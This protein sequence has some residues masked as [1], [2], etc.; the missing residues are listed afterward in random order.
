MPFGLLLNTSEQ[1]EGFTEEDTGGSSN[2]PYLGAHRVRTQSFGP[3]TENTKINNLLPRGQEVQEGR[4]VQEV[5][6]GHQDHLYQGDQLGPADRGGVSWVRTVL[7]TTTCQCF[8]FESTFFLFFRLRD[9]RSIRNMEFTFPRPFDQPQPG[10]QGS[11][12]INIQE[13]DKHISGLRKDLHPS[14]KT[15][16]SE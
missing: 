10:K 14:I 3:Q 2:Q 13:V 8:V 16:R 4:Q 15:S 5:Q 1:R 11:R 12:D 7:L 6:A 9:E